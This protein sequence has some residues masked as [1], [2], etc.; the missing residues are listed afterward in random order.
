VDDAVRVRAAQRGQ[1]LAHIT[2]RLRGR[3]RAFENLFI[4]A[5]PFH[6]FEDHDEPVANLLRRTELRDIRVLEAGMNLDLAQEAAEE[7]GVSFVPGKNDL[8]GSDPIGNGVADA[9]NLAHSTSSEDSENLVIPDRIAD[10]ETHK[11]VK[12]SE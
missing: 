5:S 7:S 8:H 2:D 12:F 10:V 4:E 6:Q 3:N 11:D 1:H 9:E